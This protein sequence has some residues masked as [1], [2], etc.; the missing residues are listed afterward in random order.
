[1]DTQLHHEGRTRPLNRPHPH[2]SAPPLHHLQLPLPLPTHRRRVA[3]L[4]F[5]EQ[6]CSCYVHASQDILLEEGCL[7]KDDLVWFMHSNGDGHQSLKGGHNLA[8]VLSGK[9][10]IVPAETM[11]MYLM[12]EPLPI[13]RWVGR[14]QCSTSF[15]DLLYSVTWLVKREE[16]LGDAWGSILPAVGPCDGFWYWGV[17]STGFRCLGLV[18]FASH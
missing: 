9:D 12:G 1:M 10:Q 14:A 13:V 4:V 8:V 5:C 3:A 18:R 6:W 7:W 15:T 17:P 11:R 16:A 2:P